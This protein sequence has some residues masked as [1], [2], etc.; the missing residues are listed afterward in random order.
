MILAA[1][2]PDPKKAG[3]RVTQK[4]T[5]SKNQDGSIR[6]VWESSGD[7]GKSWTTAFDGKY[8]RKR[9]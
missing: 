9:P 8:V 7:N 1:T 5:W 4:I 3:A 6:Q 2:A